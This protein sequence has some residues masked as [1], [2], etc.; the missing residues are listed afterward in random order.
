[1]E[2]MPYANTVSSVLFS[3]I[4][5]KPNLAYS[6]SFLN[7]FT[8]NPRKFHWARLKWLLRYIAETL[9]VGLVFKK[10][11]DLLAL[12]GYIDFD[13]VDDKD[14]RKSTTT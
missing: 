7:R 9:S 4:I 5:T 6:I 3:L 1:M 12:K 14:R 11:L 8:A 10:G 2:N 13:F